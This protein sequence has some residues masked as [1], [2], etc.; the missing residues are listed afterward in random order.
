MEDF[1]EYI[2]ENESGKYV[3]QG[4]YFNSPS[5]KAKRFYFYPLWCGECY[6]KS[7]YEIDRKYMD[8][9]IAFWIEEGELSFSFDDRQDFTATEGSLVIL[10]CKERNHYYTKSFCKFMFVHFN[11]NSI[12]P[13]YD[14]ITQ[15]KQN[16]FAI[17]EN[18][19]AAFTKLFKLMKMQVSS[20]K[21]LDY[22][23]LFYNLLIELVDRTQWSQLDPPLEHQTPS[24]VTEALSY[25]DEHFVEKVT[26]N[27]LCH[28]LGVSA[29]LLSRTFHQYTNNS[30]HEYLISVRLLHAKQLLV[31]EPHLSIAEVANL[32]GFHDASHLNKCFRTQLG[33]TPSKFRK[34]RF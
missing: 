24:M 32:C 11:G 25:L 26:I 2:P 1:S 12:Q 14:Y 33:M 15:E 21:E 5:N 34:M 27:T 30:I 10:D 6:V 28:Q 7:S 8:S 20:T 13:L 23:E 31:A 19:K 18:D 22:S 4:M 29:T 16:L 17:S 3:L 9:F